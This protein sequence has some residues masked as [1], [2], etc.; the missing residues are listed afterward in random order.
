MYLN[1]KALIATLTIGSVFLS[2]S[3]FFA[4]AT[5]TRKVSWN[6]TRPTEAA[7]WA[8]DYSFNSKNKFLSTP[9]EI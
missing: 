2:H 6:V 5:E 7:F 4:D 9:T 8:C 1:C 3:S